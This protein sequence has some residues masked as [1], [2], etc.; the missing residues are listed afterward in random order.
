M[1]ILKLISKD[2]LLKQVKVQLTQHGLYYIMLSSDAGILEFHGK[3]HVLMDFYNRINYLGI[4]TNFFEMY[5][6]E[7]QYGQRVI[8]SLYYR[9]LTNK[10]LRKPQKNQNDEITPNYVLIVVFV[11]E[12]LEHYIKY[13][14]RCSF[15]EKMDIEFLSLIRVT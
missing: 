1:N 14:M 13:C 15:Q 12:E 7:G 5:K 11:F 6:L 9:T 10:K 4:K 3:N 2:Q 8:D